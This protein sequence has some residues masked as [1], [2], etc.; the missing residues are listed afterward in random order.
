M[1]KMSEPHTSIPCL[2][3]SV[4]KTK[5]LNFL[6]KLFKFESVHYNTKMGHEQRYVPVNT[7]FTQEFSHEV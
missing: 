7:G 3:S 2:G 1:L 6:Q 5:Q 4:K